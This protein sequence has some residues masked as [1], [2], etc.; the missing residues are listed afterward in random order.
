MCCGSCASLGS[1]PTEAGL[2]ADQLIGAN[3]TGHDSHG[4]GMM[5]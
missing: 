1:E 2:V 4:V 3:L 5:P